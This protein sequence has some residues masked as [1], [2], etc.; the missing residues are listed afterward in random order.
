MAAFHSD[1]FG[2]LS[3]NLLAVSKAQFSVPTSSALAPGPRAMIPPGNMNTL[4]SA[5]CMLPLPPIPARS[6][7]Q[8]RVRTS[9][10]SLAAGLS[11]TNPFVDK[12]AAPGNP[13]RA[14]FQELEAAAWFS[15]EE[16][17]PDRPF[18]TQ[19]P[20]GHGPGQ[21]APSL[22]GFQDSFKPSV[23]LSNPKGWVTFE[24]EDDFGVKGKPHSTSSN[25][26]G[27]TQPR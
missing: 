19:N 10:D 23:K 18:P 22:E 25:L 8:E 7:S 27:G 12:S 14:E 24:D 3:F 1:P 26:W 2:D 11:R 6:K 17:L 13:F 15:Q 21:P 5:S 20:L 4:S 9:L 16:P